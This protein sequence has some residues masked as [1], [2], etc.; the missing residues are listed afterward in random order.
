MNMKKSLIIATIFAFSVISSSTYAGNGDGKEVVIGLNIG[1]RAPEI[2]EKALDGKE[3]KLSALQGKLVLIDFWAAWCGPCRKENPNL[4][5]AYHK[6]KDSKFTSGKGFT[7]YSVSLDKDKASWE[8]AIQADKLEWEN[9]VSDLLYW[10]SK[11]AGVY[12][13]RSI[14]SNFLIDADGIILAKNLRGP[15]LEQTLSKLLK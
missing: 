11:Y 10:N 2:I 1:N 5:Q 7:V 13:V 15:V 6:F 4:V 3:L 9:H 12:G 14:P 8:Q